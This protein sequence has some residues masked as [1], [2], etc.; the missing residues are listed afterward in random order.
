VAGELIGSDRE[1][2]AGQLTFRFADPSIAPQLSGRSWS[3]VSPVTPTNAGGTYTFQ[4]FV[5]DGAQET[6]GTLTIHVS[7]APAPPPPP[8][9]AA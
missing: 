4:Y 2:P 1:T 8:P 5:G 7:P 6:P 9:P 3:W